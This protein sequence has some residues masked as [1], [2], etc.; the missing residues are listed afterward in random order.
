MLGYKDEED[1]VLAIIGLTNNADNFPPGSRGKIK[2]YM[3]PQV[4]IQLFPNLV[5]S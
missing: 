3:E 4:G 2:S 5:G 1:T